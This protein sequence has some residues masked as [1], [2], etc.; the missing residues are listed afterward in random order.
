MARL[1]DLRR[2]HGLSQAKL[3]AVLGLSPST[4]ALYELGLRNPRLD[5]AR[6]I[7]AYFGA[8]LDQ[9]EFASAGRA[10]MLGQQAGARAR[11]ETP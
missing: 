11:S 4:I 3:A 1:A 8:S 10:V 6:R 7:A 5:I 9:L 2:V